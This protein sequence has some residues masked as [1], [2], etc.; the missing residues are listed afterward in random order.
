M[1]EQK[2]VV[3]EAKEAEKLV[4][5]AESETTVENG[6]IVD[7]KAKKES[8]GT[9]LMKPIKWVGR[10]IKNHPVETVVGITATV[11]GAFAARKAY[12]I[13]H[14]RGFADGVASV[15]VPE[16]IEAP[17]KDELDA[18]TEMENEIPNEVDGGVQEIV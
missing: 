8:L 4:N 12:E 13:G 1:S 15:P 16:A 6:H 9:K 3:V 11:L 14:D 7:P 10:K 5:E 17:D 2:K 18:L